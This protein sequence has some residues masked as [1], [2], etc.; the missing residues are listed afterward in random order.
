MDAIIDKSRHSKLVRKPTSN[1]FPGDPESLLKYS[2]EP[3]L[4]NFAP[5]VQWFKEDP[6]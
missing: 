1:A 3:F 5:A 6:I 2:S 4:I